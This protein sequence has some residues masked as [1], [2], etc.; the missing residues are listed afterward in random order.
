[1]QELTALKLKKGTDSIAENMVICYD[2]LIKS[3]YILEDERALL[4]SW[5]EDITSI[6]S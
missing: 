3:G 6:L 4:A 5:L 2:Q 1:M